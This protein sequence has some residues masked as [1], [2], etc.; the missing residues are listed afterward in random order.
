M[1][2]KLERT[3]VSEN[4]YRT[5]SGAYYREAHGGV[6]AKRLTERR[7]AATERSAERM[8]ARVRDAS[9]KLSFKR[10]KVSSDIRK[11]GEKHT[12]S[13]DDEEAE[14][15]VSYDP[16]INIELATENARI[17]LD[18]DEPEYDHFNIEYL[19]TISEPEGAET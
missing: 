2:R 5:P 18:A 14:V 3:Y 19:E 13:P 8:K 15:D 9:G 4:V 7:G 16:D 10:I 12:G 1:T 6:H 11:S 17:H